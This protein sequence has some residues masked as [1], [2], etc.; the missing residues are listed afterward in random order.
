MT[1]TMI[2]INPVDLVVRFSWPRS[3]PQSEFPIKKYGHLKLRWSDFGF[4]LFYLSSLFL[5]SFFFLFFV[6][7]SFLFLYMKVDEKELVIRGVSV[8]EFWFL[9]HWIRINERWDGQSVRANII[10][11]MRYIRFFYTWIFANGFL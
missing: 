3:T 2:A 1:V 8:F 9:N 7:L 4:Y 10:G 5:I 6:S 11:E